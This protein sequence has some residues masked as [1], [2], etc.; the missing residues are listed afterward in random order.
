M[1][2]NVL[3]FGVFD[4]LHRGHIYFL[5]KAKSHGDELVIS[6]ARDETII[7]LKGARPMYSFAERKHAL[8]ETG[9]VCQII[10]GDYEIG[11]FRSISV[12]RPQIICLGYDQEQL[13]ES[14]TIWMK[15]FG[16]LIPLI[17]LSSFNPQMYKSSLLNV[18]K[19][20]PYD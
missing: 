20:T 1:K 19:Q 9:L 15:K 16:I 13:K 7:E 6:L 10:E 18:N 3:A 8:E 14:L 11:A 5:E 4:G 12:T 2:K 17:T